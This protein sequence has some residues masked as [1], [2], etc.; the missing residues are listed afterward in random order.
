MLTNTRSNID[1]GSHI[2]MSS[3]QFE[4]YYNPKMCPNTPNLC[5]THTTGIPVKS[6]KDHSLPV[7]Y[8]FTQFLNSCWVCCII[9]E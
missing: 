8:Q 4:L 2:L 1:F 3:Q 5:T 7:T 6:M 9:F